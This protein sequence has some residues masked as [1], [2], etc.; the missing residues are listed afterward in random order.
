MFTIYKLTSPS[1]K[2]Y[3][4]YTSRSMRE[5]LT[6]HKSAAKKKQALIQKAI[7]RYSLEQWTVDVL[8]ETEDQQEAFAFEIATILDYDST[9]PDKGYNNSTGGES[10]PFGCKRSAETR[11]LISASKTGKSMPEGWGE[12]H[13]EKLRGR[14]RPQSQ[15][16][17]AR[18]ANSKEWLVTHPCGKQEKLVNLRQ[19][20]KEHKLSQGNLCVYGKTKGYTAVLIPQ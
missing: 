2:V 8:L 14:P 20:C 13:A 3:I 10:G 6:D 11:A 4:G 17:A 12:R 15:K 18:D 9:N 19:F 1:G 7:S 16:D 5:R